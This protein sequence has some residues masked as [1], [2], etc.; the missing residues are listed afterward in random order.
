MEANSASRMPHVHKDSRVTGWLVPRNMR[1][2]VGRVL[3]Y[4]ALLVAFVAFVGP[5]YWIFITAVK[6]KEQLFVMPP[7]FW[8]RE[9][10]WRNFY[11]V[12]FE[13][14]PYPTYFL[15]T[16]KIAF[17]NVVGRTLSAALVAYGFTVG[18]FRGREVWFSI[19]LATMMVPRQV[20]LI[21]LFVLFSR[22][23]WVNT[24]LPLSVPGFFG[25]GAYYIFLLRQFFLSIPDELAEAARMDGASTLRTWWNIYLPNSVPAL[26]AVAV[27]C[28]MNAWNDYFGGLIYLQKRSAWTVTVGLAGMRQNMNVMDYNTQMAGAFMISIPCV[29]VFFLAQRYF[30]EGVTMS[31]VKG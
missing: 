1:S 16:F 6:P 22:V 12:F 28:F 19:L 9:F 18:E 7:A 24:I 5:I 29:V 2:L 10:V 15:N 27:F 13:L 31:G 25:G 17:L 11:H 21:P 23:G 8:P 14:A 4:G 3:T 26:T 20:T 30:T